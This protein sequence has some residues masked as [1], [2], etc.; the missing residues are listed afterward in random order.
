LLNMSGKESFGIHDAG[1]FILCGTFSSVL[2][3]LSSCYAFR[4]IFDH[5]I[6]QC[7]S[8]VI[9]YGCCLLF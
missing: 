5:Y 1:I 4:G 8:C 3:S 2:K 9:W 7:S 6:I